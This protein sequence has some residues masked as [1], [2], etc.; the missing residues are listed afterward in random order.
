MHQVRAVGEVKLV[1]R[2]EVHAQFFEKASCNLC[3]DARR[4]QSAQ[5]RFNHAQ[6]A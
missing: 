1:L 3:C 6:N 4:G 2:T 5:V